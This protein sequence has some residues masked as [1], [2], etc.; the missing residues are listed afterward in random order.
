M[1]KQQ[2]ALKAIQKK[3][4]GKEL[5]YKEIYAIMDEIANDRLGDIL[6][7]Y[8]AASG[9]S[10]GFTY[11]E[12]YFLTKAMVETGEKLS[13]KGIVADKHSIGGLPGTRCTMIIVP[14][15]AAAGFTIPKSSSRAITTPAGTADVMEVLA[16]VTFDEKQIYEIV[17]KTK[18][19]IVWGGSF[20]IAPA[21]DEII[22]VEEPLLLESYDKILVSVMAKKIAFGSNHVVIDIP[23]GKSMK[24]HRMEDAQ[25]LGRKFKFIANKFDMK[26][27]FILSHTAEP[28]G[29][30]IGP[31]L[32]AIDVLKVL[33]QTPDR[34]IALEQRSVELSAALLRLCLEDAPDDIKEAAK[35]Y[36]SEEDWAR[37]LLVTGRAHA[38]MME[39]IKVQKGNPE[40]TSSKLHPAPHKKTIKSDK[41]GDITFVNSKNISLIAKILGAPQDAKSG[42]LLHKKL[43]YKVKNGEELFTMFSESEHRLS[44]AIDSLEMFPIHK[45]E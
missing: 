18:G 23:Y 27:E 10:K 41:S 11:D 19:C 35:R 13:F 4:V 16:Q 44:E 12:L 17:E 31:L 20:K 21:D 42:I 25:S 45:I 40:I 15:I 5:N 9:Y 32:E 2:A 33:E 37:A 43:K 26:L 7:T 38:K 3:L 39:I 36:S 8:F 24:V 1:D 14:I 22:Q 30:G 6:T 34:P 29:N 28:A